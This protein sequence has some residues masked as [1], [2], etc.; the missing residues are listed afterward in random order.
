MRSRSASDD[1][2]KQAEAD[3]QA[4]LDEVKRKARDG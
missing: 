1:Q 4:M 2:V 3:V